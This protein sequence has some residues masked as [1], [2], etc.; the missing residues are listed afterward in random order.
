MT[1]TWPASWVSSPE[2]PL[3]DASPARWGGKGLG[4]LRLAAGG[5]QVPEFFVLSADVLLAAQAMGQVN[6]TLPGFRALL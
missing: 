2:K 4:L 6:V 3:L 5:F 1:E